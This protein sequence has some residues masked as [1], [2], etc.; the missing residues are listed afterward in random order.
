[1]AEYKHFETK[2]IRTQNQP[3][4]NREHSG[5]LYMTSSFAFEN[6][7][8][9]EA[10]FD[11]KIPGNIYTRFSNPNNDE[12]IQK[13]CVLEGTDD[14]I[15]TASGMAALFSSMAGLLGSGDHILSSRSIFG[16]IHQVLA[17]IFPRWGI[18]YS[19]ADVDKPEEWEKL[20]KKN[21]KMIFAETPSNPGLDI[22]DLK[23]LGDL[24]KSH[25]LILNIDNTFAS[26]YI[27]NPAKFGANIITH[28]ATKYID[29]QGRAIAGAILGDQ[30][31]IDNIR[32]FTR[33][34]GPA[35]SPFNGWL[36]S[37]SLETLSIRMEKHCENALRIAKYLQGHEELET[38]KYPFLQSHPQYAMAKSQMSLGGGVVTFVVKGGYERAW[39]FIDSLKMMKISANLG[40]S[41]SIITHPATTTHSKL[42]TAEQE[43][44]GIKPGLVR[45]SV[46]LE[47]ANDILE[48]IV[49][50]LR[51]SKNDNKTP[52][53]N[54]G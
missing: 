48:D 37:K 12:F 42:T 51:I 49:N 10:L 54:R 3:S 41:R 14:G 2:A 28:S 32:P 18:E 4:A 13:L 30:E 25:D 34:T 38:I 33:T 15:P 24:A 47:N 36:L 6:S 52:V 29:G 35:L 17:S 20:I 1:M 26:P 11:D 46:G 44:V 5:S 45:V 31:L 7:E 8:Q 27:Q 23:W 22:I 9:A 21:T 40:D 19:Y 39:K 16:P 43:K 50:A 53:V